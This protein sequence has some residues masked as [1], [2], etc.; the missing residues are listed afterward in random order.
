MSTIYNLSHPY[1]ENSFWGNME[2]QSTNLLMLKS[3]R[4]NWSIL[5]KLMA[6][7]MSKLRFI[8]DNFVYNLQFVA[9]RYINAFSGKSEK[10]EKSIKWSFN[11]LMFKSSKTNWSISTNLSSIERP[12]LRFIR[13][14]FVYN[15]EFVIFRYIK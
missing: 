12:K 3:W 11:L 6:I 4:A 7:E 8:K 5:R 2:N 13:D 10:P 1:L 14:N 15:L 9:F